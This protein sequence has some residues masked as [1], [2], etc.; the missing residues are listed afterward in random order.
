MESDLRYKENPK[1]EATGFRGLGEERVVE[2]QVRL[3]RIPGCLLGWE[4]AVLT[5]RGESVQKEHFGPRPC[6]KPGHIGACVLGGC[7]A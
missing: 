6:R 1:E 7:K 3:T 2:T 4:G 5:T